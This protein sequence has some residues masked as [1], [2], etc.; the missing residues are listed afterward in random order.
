MAKRRE[1]SRQRAVALFSVPMRGWLWALAGLTLV[2]AGRRQGWRPLLLGQL[3]SWSPWE[4]GAQF[5][6]LLLVSVALAALLLSAVLRI[7][8]GVDG[9][10]RT[11]W[12]C[13]GEELPPY[14]LSWPGWLAVIQAIMLEET[15]ARVLFAMVLPDL[16]GGPFIGWALGGNLL[17][18]L[19]HLTNRG[20]GRPHPLKVLPQFAGGLVYLV[21]FL[22]FG[23]I[24]AVA[25]HL[26]YDITAYALPVLTRRAALYR[27]RWPVLS[28]RRSGR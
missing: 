12:R 2:S 24:A 11:E 25:A 10:P 8:P 20:I 13:T 15:L 22:L 4:A 26:F 14:D 28:A 9:Q 6:L 16:L 5:A 21:A 7:H 27:Q 3:T 18:S 23:L 17:W 19:L 1:W